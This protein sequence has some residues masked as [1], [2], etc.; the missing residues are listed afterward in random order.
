VGQCSR[1]SPD[2]SLGVRTACADNQT[3]RR[4][5]L[6]AFVVTATATGCS[7]SGM[8][9]QSPVV[10]RSPTLGVVWA[11][12]QR[13]YGHVKPST[14]DNGGDPTGLVEHVRWIGWGTSHAVGTGTGWVPPDDGPYNDFRHTTV[15]VVVS[16]L[17]L[18]RR[19][20]AY[21]TLQWIF[22]TSRKFRRG[23]RWNICTGDEVRATTYLPG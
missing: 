16:N 2:G 18:C 11:P 3:V 14:V 15:K 5:V 20:F 6:V 4:V 23:G 12:F 22:P 8:R 10:R 19:R 17:G 1:M 9:A 7:R 21:R 13:G